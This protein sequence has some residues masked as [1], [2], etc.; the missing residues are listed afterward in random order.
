LRSPV[1]DAR[2][3]DQTM[4][5]PNSSVEKIN[6]PRLA[7]LGIPL[8]ENSSFLQGPALAPPLIREAFRSPSSNMWSETGIYLGE[9]D[10]FF[11]AGDI[12]FISSQSPFTEIE[13]AV[14]HLLGDGYTPVS[15]GGDHSITYP[16][17]RAFGRKFPRLSILH[18]DAHPDIYDEFEG[19]RFSHACPF[20]R[21]MEAGLA[22]RLVQVGI[23]TMSGHQ[24]EQAERFGVEVIEMRHWRDD[25][26]LE[27][28]SPLYISFDMDALDP[29]FSPGVSH[30]EPGG[31]ST[32][33]AINLIQSVKAS[34]VGADIVEYNP[35]QDVS[36]VTAMV[37][38]R[39]MKEIAAKII[40]GA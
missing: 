14:S 35:R 23:R 38:G 33:Q 26:K 24:R 11:D 2:L 36:N 3:I 28:D 13:A 16:I 17:I 8:D 20:A 39:L 1:S 29:A 21:I 40:I 5:D 22:D 15:L 31:L 6:S 10:L 7:L 4:K 25:L 27:F 12:K 34:V 32:R 18:F 37:C 19:N 30:R 9:D